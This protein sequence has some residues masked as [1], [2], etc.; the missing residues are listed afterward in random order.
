MHDT[1]IWRRQLHL[2][3]YDNL[4]DDAMPPYI[5]AQNPTVLEFLSRSAR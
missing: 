2:F 4:L 1:S 3:G 5:Q